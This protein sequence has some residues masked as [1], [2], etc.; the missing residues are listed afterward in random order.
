MRVMT[1]AIAA[2]ALI[3]IQATPALSQ[4]TTPGCGPPGRECPRH[5]SCG[6]GH[7]PAGTGGA[8]HRGCCKTG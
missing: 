5:E 3:A 7:C 4:T 8:C 2:A 1:S 6:A